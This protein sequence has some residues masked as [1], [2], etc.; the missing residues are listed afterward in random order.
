MRKKTRRKQ[1]WGLINPLN[2][3]ILGAGITQEHL[4]DKLRLRELTA[5]DVMSRGVGTISEWQELADLLNVCQVMGMEGI[6][7]EVLPVCE[8][9]QEA[10]V[11]AARGYE[12]TKKMLLS[13]A[14]V[15]AFREIYEY[16][17]LQRKSVARSVYEKMIVKTRQRLKSRAKEVF[18]I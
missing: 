17:D 16:H 11:Q 14:G 7:P 3:A 15:N 10:L 8:E 5:I 2:H 1:Q 18:E 4:L 9:A 12:Q 6:G 13:D